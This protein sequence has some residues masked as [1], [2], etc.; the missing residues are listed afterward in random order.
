MDT[1]RG[2][3]KTKTQGAGFG[4]SALEPEKWF[5]KGAAREPWGVVTDVDLLEALC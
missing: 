4:N 5:S 1:V 2:G 3:G